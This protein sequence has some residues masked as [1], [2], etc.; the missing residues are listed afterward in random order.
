MNISTVI[1]K[2]YPSY[3]DAANDLRISVR[4]VE[5]IVKTG[6]I[7]SAILNK[8]YHKHKVNP[9]WVLWGIG[10]WKIEIEIEN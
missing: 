2:I 4:K 8:L 7:S 6:K 9:A 1:S 10:E 5:A 3:Q